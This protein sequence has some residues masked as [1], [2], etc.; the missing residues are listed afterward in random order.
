[1]NLKAKTVRVVSTDD[2]ELFC[3]PPLTFEASGRI[4]DKLTAE[5][6]QWFKG[7]YDP[8]KTVEFIP[9]LFMSV[10]QNGDTYPLTTTADAEALRAALGDG[11]LLDLVEAFWDYD[12]RFFA[13]RRAASANSSPALDAGEAS[14]PS[15]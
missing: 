2:L 9:Q 11:F 4:N 12:Y 13:R 1:M 5:L 14:K 7:G 10:S 15:P 8:A 3:D 6:Q